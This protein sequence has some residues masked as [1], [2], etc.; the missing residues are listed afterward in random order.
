MAVRPVNEQQLRAAISSS[1]PDR[2]FEVVWSPASSAAGAKQASP[3]QL[4][5]S[6]ATEDDPVAASYLRT[7][8]V[9]AAVQSWLTGQETGV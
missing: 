1:G 4:L 9:L 3:H 7:H 2:L 6:V 8:Q 5:E